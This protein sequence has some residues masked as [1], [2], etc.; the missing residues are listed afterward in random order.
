MVIA[1][2]DLMNK[3][4]VQLEQGRKKVLERNDHR[5]L[6]KQFDRYGETAV[7]DLDR[8]LGTGENKKIVRELMKHGECRV[9]GGIRTVKD[10]REMINWGARKVIVGSRAFEHDQVNTPFLRALRTAIGRERIVIAVDA[11]RGQIVT[12]GWRHAT[13]LNLYCTAQTCEKY[14]GEFLYTCVQ[15]EGMMK[16]IDMRAVKALRKAVDCRLTVAGGVRS[17]S[18]IKLLAKSGADVQLG[19]A[20]Y[21]GR[22]K[23]DK[24]FIGS[25]DWEK[26]NGLIPTITQDGSGKV[27]MLAYSRR[28]SLQRA[29]DTGKMCYYSRSRKKLWTK[30]ENSGNTQT[31]VRIRADCDRDTLLA[32]VRQR[33]VA[34][35]EGTYTCFG[36][37]APGSK[38]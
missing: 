18:E 35:H 30:G 2:I 12:A 25:L 24:A 34:C 15:R 7:I 31:L 23:L 1:S 28:D 16:G 6:I 14:C 32:V 8:A 37:I 11:V 22:I 13:G 29:F 27:L 36:D 26:G 3:R 4:V 20:L 33:G 10:A 17:I 19:M 9:G 21:T 5:I 38:K